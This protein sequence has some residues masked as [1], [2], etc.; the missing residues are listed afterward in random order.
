MSAMSM[1]LTHA[2]ASLRS[3]RLIIWRTLDKGM[4]NL[5]AKSSTVKRCSLTGEFVGIEIAKDQHNVYIPCQ[6]KDSKCHK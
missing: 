1:R 6:R 3:T 2:H 5:S 4:R